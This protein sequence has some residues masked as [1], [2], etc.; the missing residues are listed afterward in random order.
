VGT[1]KW[2]LN[3][4]YTSCLALSC[5]SLQ[6]HNVIVI[7]CHVRLQCEISNLIDICNFF[8]H[9]AR[10][11]IIFNYYFDDCNSKRK[12][13]QIKHDNQNF[14]FPLF[15]SCSELLAYCMQNTHNRAGNLPPT[16]FFYDR[17]SV[18]AQ[19]ENVVLWVRA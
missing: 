2:R 16:A 11:N 12:K 7:F 8:L 19:P 14:I 10:I 6:L 4:E 9:I 13:F 18:A 3:E 15:F 1:Q 5:C 17:K